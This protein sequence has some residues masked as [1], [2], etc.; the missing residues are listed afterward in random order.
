MQVSSSDMIDC[1]PRVTSDF[2][3]AMKP[4]K[5]GEKEK[6]K[7]KRERGECMLGWRTVDLSL[8]SHASSESR[9]QFVYI[10]FFGHMHPLHGI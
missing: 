2:G 4:E 7:K 9:V 10:A 8:T 5:K 6:R 3:E 1:E